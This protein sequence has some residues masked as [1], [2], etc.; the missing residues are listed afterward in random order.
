MNKLKLFLENFLVYGLGGVISQ[1]VPLIM[2]PIVTHIM[3][4]TDYYGIT[5]MSQT[6]V[7]FCSAIALMGMYDA[8]Y[9]MFFEKEEREYKKTVCSTALLFTIASSFIVFLLMI[10]FKTQIAGAFYNN[11]N[12]AYVVY[13]TAMSTLVGATNGIISAPTRMENKRKIFL[14]TNTLSPVF[15]YSIAIPLL[16]AGHYI[17]ALPLAY[18]LS[19]LILEASFACM[20]HKWFSL[21]LFD[22][23][24]LKKMLIIAL[25]LMP[26]FLVYWLFNSADRLMITHLIGIGASGIYA[27]GAKLGLA[28]QLIYTAFAGGWQFFAFSTMK[29]ENQVHTNSRIF[30]YLGGISFAATM[31]ICALAEPIYA[32]IFDKAYHGAFIVSPYLFLA[33]LLQMLFQVAANQFL[34]IKKTWPNFF[35][36]AVGALVNIIINYVMIPRIGIEGAA[37]AT[38]IGYAL[39]D[40]ICCIVLIKMDLMVLSSRFIVAVLITGMLLVMWRFVFIHHVIF[41]LIAAVGLSLILVLLYREDVMRIVNAL[42]HRGDNK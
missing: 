39:A 31:F 19:A 3:P 21:R 33:P 5:D 42:I 29:E 15:S 23:D 14:I 11:K 26:N 10:I 40:I 1:I 32:L 28:S 36:L 17:I 37:L 16:L 2:V 35:I 38:L 30:E 6:I 8:M 27:V 41:T 24:L 18:A 20:N 25:P 7:S 13:I 12:L 34:V 22:K 4:N 9:R